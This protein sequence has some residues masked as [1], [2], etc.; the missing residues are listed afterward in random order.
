LAEPEPTDPRGA[1]ASTGHRWIQAEPAWLSPSSLEE[2]LAL[3][4]E[5]GDEATV[6]AGGTFVGI[7]MNQGF[8]SPGAFLWLGAVPELREMAV[9]DGEL[10]L[11]AM[12]THRRVEREATGWPVL[13]RA[14][15]L[16]ASPRVR[17]VAT[18]GGVLADADYASDPPAM[19]AALDA[20][21]VLRSP[22]GEREVGVGELI[23]GHYV[24]SIQRDELLVEV[25]VPAEPRRATYRKFR[26]RS[27]EDR[28]CVAVAAV[29]G[30]DG[31]RVVVGA[32]AD[33]PQ[34]FPELCDGSPAEI[35]ARYA[36][37]IEPLSD[38]RGTAKY[39]CRV[40]AAEV[41]RAVEEVGWTPA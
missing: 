22:E 41:R 6:L 5:Q 26:S 20:R 14:F 8:L 33:R 15:G 37:R 13:A 32:V 12:V 18:V 21:A 35:G 1:E 40:I 9:V 39:R 28:P 36:E 27:S 30:D 24:T 29:N 3:R 23:L 16:V 4:A 31:L 38:S 7:L 25:R 19:L 10:R 17:N 2:A 34:D 11:G